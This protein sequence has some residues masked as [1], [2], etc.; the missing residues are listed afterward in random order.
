MRLNERNYYE[1]VRKATRND[2]ISPN[3]FMEMLESKH[4]HEHDMYNSDNINK[5]EKNYF[6]LYMGKL[7]NYRDINKSSSALLLT[8]V[9]CKKLPFLRFREYFICTIFQKNYR[10]KTYLAFLKLIEFRK[11]RNYNL[12][13]INRQSRIMKK[14]YGSWAKIWI[15][16][17]FK[18]KIDWI[19]LY[20][21]RKLEI[22]KRVC[23]LIEQRQ[24]VK[25]KEALLNK[26][27]KKREYKKS[28]LTKILEDNYK[29]AMKQVQETF[30][31]Q[32]LKILIKGQDVPGTRTKLV[33][34]IFD[35]VFELICDVI[36][37]AK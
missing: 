14:F 8:G 24:I 30:P 16:S 17:M 37:Q 23:C 7:Q 26:N 20:G 29:Q 33:G 19:F 3:R 31:K 34:L 25:E 12:K 21:M 10:K 36:S 5:F 22:H 2:R 4:D 9:W 6:R 15:Y 27:L 35:T 1:N 11:I 32:F 18:D 28:D 13:K